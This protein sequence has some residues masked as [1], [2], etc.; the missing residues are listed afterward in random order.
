MNSSLTPEVWKT[1]LHKGRIMN[2]V[3]FIR[4]SPTYCVIHYMISTVS[5]E[6]VIAPSAEGP[7]T[8][9]CMVTGFYPKDI[10]VEWALDG[11][12]VSFNVLSTDV[13]PNHDLTYQ[14]RKTLTVSAPEGNYSCKVEHRSLPQP[15]VIHWGMLGLHKAQ[16]ASTIITIH[17]GSR[18]VTCSSAGRARC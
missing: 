15:L 8:L 17:V 18:C 3:T 10:T 6:V 2:V 12:P 14:I 5:P 1:V 9:T 4:G 16:N 11:E 7:D 13:L